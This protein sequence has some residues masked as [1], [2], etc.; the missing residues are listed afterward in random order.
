MKRIL[1]ETTPESMKIDGAILYLKECERKDA[2]SE[3]K[4]S[5]SRRD[6]STYTL[7]CSIRFFRHLNCICIYN[8]QKTDA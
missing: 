3:M 2:V 8:T 7:V 1:G 4:S 6:L 5:V